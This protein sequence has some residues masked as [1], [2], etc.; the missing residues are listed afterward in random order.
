M[1][2]RFILDNLKKDLDFP[3]RENM[4]MISELHELK[5][6]DFELAQE[7]CMSVERK[8]LIYDEIATDSKQLAVALKEIENI[9]KLREKQQD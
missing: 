6:C 3:T 1:N 9:K 8:T 2:E 7:N 4:K 5:L